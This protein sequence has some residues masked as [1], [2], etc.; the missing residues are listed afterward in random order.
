MDNKEL[1]MLLASVV[2]KRER[3]GS[4]FDTIE[5]LNAYD[6]YQGAVYKT[7]S[8]LSY[9]LSHQDLYFLNLPI[10]TMNE[11]IGN[12]QGIRN[13]LDEKQ[14]EEL[15]SR[16]RAERE[17]DYVELNPYYRMLMGLPVYG[18]EGHPL[19]FEVD[20]IE[21]GKLLHTLTD[22]EVFLLKEFDL[23]TKIKNFYPDQD[24][25][26]YLDKR[27]Q[28][29]VSRR[30]DKFTLLYVTSDVSTLLSDKFKSNFEKNR[31]Y[32]MRCEFNS[33][34]YDNQEFYEDS[35]ILYL[36]GATVITTMSDMLVDVLDYELTDETVMNNIFLGAGFKGYTFMPKMYKVKLMEKFSLLLTKTGSKDC[37]VD[38]AGLFEINF[39]YRYVLKKRRKTDDWDENTPLSQR[40][41]LSFVRV[42][43]EEK[44]I[45]NYL[46][47]KTD[48]DVPFDEFVRNDPKWGYGDDKLKDEVLQRSFSYLETKYISIENMIDI[49]KVTSEIAMFFHYIFKTKDKINQVKVFHKGNKE[50]IKLFDLIV[51]QLALVCL[52]NSYGDD[53]PDTCEGWSYVIGMNTEESFDELKH[54]FMVEYMGSNKED[55]LDKIKV[56]E[57]NCSGEE[58]LE[59]YAHN[60]N[61]IQEIKDVLARE[62]R[63]SKYQLCHKFTQAAIYTKVVPEAFNGCNT[64]SKYIEKFTSLYTRYRT[65]VGDDNDTQLKEEIALVN[66][67]LMD[68]TDSFNTDIA[69]FYTES[70]FYVDESEFDV[71][72]LFLDKVIDFFRSYTTDL[73]E[74]DTIF[75]INDIS[76]RLGFV[77]DVTIEEKIIHR[78][79]VHNLPDET[80]GEEMYM[81]QH[82]PVNMKC[83]YSFKETLYIIEGDDIDVV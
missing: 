48:T 20:G 41:D 10:D 46:K 50:W 5:S 31:R 82:E 62:N 60:Y 3:Y 79:N 35:M 51:Y 8:V 80:K 47:K 7:D 36:I 21:S 53:I 18:H 2:V 29:Y 76:I 22:Q 72:K 78:E 17:R 39:I 9:D 56:L 33:H 71:I 49:A 11:I 61:I 73:R 81:I 74:F 63:Y 30:Y 12:P 75:R 34:F 37:V 64:Y 67:S 55:L 19:P 40:Y 25:I 52:R 69:P 77:E 59:T 27:I 14:H 26:D 13:Y 70:F 54:Y 28:P 16:L 15:M 44:N 83:G 23:L 45:Y 57:K 24:Y 43:Y 65:F 32:F 58:F 66:E 68:F 38:L 42:P 4:S 6:M 1:N